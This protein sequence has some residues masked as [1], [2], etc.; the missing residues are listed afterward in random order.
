M[1]KILI[2]LLVAAAFAAGSCTRKE[3]VVPA[4]VDFADMVGVI[5][6]Y[7]VTEPAVRD[8]LIAGMMPQT[9][10][11]VK[12]VSPDSLCDSV[13]T[14]WST[15][16]TVRVFTPAVDSVFPSREPVRDALAHIVGAA[17]AEGL[18]LPSRHYGAVIY[19][20]PQAIL[21]VDSVMLIGL[22]HFLGADYPGY[23]RWPVYIRNTKTPAQLPYA[24]AEALVATSYPY[25]LTGE[26]A[27][28]LSRM[29]H[30]G[31]LVKARMELVADSRLNEALGYNEEDMKWLADNEKRL[32]EE[33]VESGLLYDTSE[34]TADRLLAPAPA[35][36]MLPTMWPGRAAR[37]I[38]YRIVEA[39]MRRNPDLTLA[40]MLSPEKNSAT[41][42]LAGAEYKP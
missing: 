21:F 36:Q 40:D 29:I 20:K 17:A 7:A 5:Y 13:L 16:L 3:A 19:G 25:S 27:T 18:E 34:A 32:W 22:N 4:E 10:A 41:A 12:V 37:Y 35:V 11:L 9:E 8:S 26:D 30:E 28:L 2:L 15:R 23:G 6:D 38:G 33:I 39:Y 14:E 1:Q 42:V 31:A 24:M